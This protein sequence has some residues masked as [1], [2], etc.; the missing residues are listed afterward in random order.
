M[1]TRYL[2]VTTDQD[3]VVL[4]WDYSHD[5][6]LWVY[7]KTNRTKKVGW[8]IDGK[9]NT[10]ARG[11]ITLDV[12][13]KHGPGVETTQ[14]MNLA[15]GTVEVWVNHYNNQFAES[16]V[17]ETPATVDIFC[18]QCLDDENEV[19]A[20]FVTPITQV[21]ADVPSGG[22]NWWK[23]TGEFVATACVRTADCEA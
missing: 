19:K 13:V 21:A 8:N 17:F 4:S 18:C 6:D 14:F 15:S 22:R 10:C 16:L 9:T 1:G 3:R 2:I 7:E 20:G 11:T 5:L 12:D 23:A